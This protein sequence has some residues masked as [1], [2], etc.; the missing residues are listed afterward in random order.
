MSPPDG[1]TRHA[2]SSP[3]L[4]LIGSLYSRGAGA[5]CSLPCGRTG[6]T[7]TVF[8]NCYLHVAERRIARASGIYASGRA[9]RIGGRAS[10]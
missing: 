6:V 4:D 10:G 7:P 1:F 5:A 2:R 9:A 3:F 8:A